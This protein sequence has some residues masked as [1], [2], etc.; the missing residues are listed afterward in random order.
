M[1]KLPLALINQKEWTYDCG[2]CCSEMVAQQVCTSYAA[3]VRKS[4]HVYAWV[5]TFLP[6]IWYSFLQNNC[7]VELVWLNPHLF[8]KADI[9]Q[10]QE[11]YKIRL[12][13][14]L[15]ILGKKYVWMKWFIKF[16]NAGWLL[17]PKII[18][19]ECIENALDNDTYIIASVTD[20]WLYNKWN[21]SYNFHY[22]CISWYDENNFYVHAPLSKERNLSHYCLIKKEELLYSIHA[23]SYGDVDNGCY[24]L[25]KNQNEN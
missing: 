13:E 11:D 21:P 24:L 25:I 8:T 18:N 6:Q 20:S 15:P 4:L 7:H 23:S 22:I 3:D 5:W 9:W 19:R 12:K 1:K 17:V 16:I 2:L 14:L 10:S